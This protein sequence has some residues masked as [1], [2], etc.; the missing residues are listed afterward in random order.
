MGKRCRKR[1]RQH[2]ALIDRHDPRAFRQK[3]SQGA[4]Q[5]FPIGPLRAIAV[6]VWL[7]G[8]LLYCSFPWDPAEPRKRFPKNVFFQ[9]N[10]LGQVD[11]LIM[12]A[13]THAKM[14]A[15]S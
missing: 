15:G 14:G 12:A 6:A 11:M 8:V 3:V 9:P 5:G 2:W 10:L 13:P 7:R 4:R 1:R